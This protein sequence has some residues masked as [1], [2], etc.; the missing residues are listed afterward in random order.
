[1]VIIINQSFWNEKVSF[2]AILFISLGLFSFVIGEIISIFIFR[3]KSKNKFYNQMK[4]FNKI[5]IPM[6]TIIFLTIIGIFIEIYY[7]KY[8]YKLALAGGYGINGRS[9]L[10]NARAAM[11]DTSINIAPSWILKFGRSALEGFSLI[12]IYIF[13]YNKVFA[14]TKKIEWRYL[15]PNILYI[16]QMILSTGRTELIY[17]IMYILILLFIIWKIRYNWSKKIDFRIIKYALIGIII[18]LISF[19]LL[20]YL[21]GKSQY[22]NL[23]NNFSIY[24]GSP[25]IAF[26]KYLN[27]NIT[28]TIFGEETLS[29][30]YRIMNHFGFDFK[31]IAVPLEPVIWD[32]VKTNIYTSLRRYIQDYTILGMILI[33]FIL[34]LLYGS[35]FNW[36]KRKNLIGFPLI[37]FSKLFYPVLE[38]VIEERFFNLVLT[39]GSVYDVIMLYIMYKVLIHK[40]NQSEF[41]PL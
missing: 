22:L 1:M 7:F 30:F 31:I 15:L 32:N 17:F 37:L 2:L 29:N 11:L 4:D 41:Y 28:N 38:S 9:I 19:R 5:R 25:I 34:G 36:I 35:W 26:S 20:G 3:R 24:L 23:W 33:Q 12:C 8:I 40:Y 16:I 18:F 21:T 13:I 27:K 10:F 14:N 6:Y 39:P